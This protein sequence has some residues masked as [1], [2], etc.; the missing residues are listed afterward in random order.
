[1]LDE[2]AAG[3]ALRTGR[4]VLLALP[5][6]AGVVFRYDNTNPDARTARLVAG[7][8]VERAAGVQDKVPEADDLVRERGSRYIDF[9]IPGLLGMNLMGSGMWGSDFPSWMRGG[10]SCSNG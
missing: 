10:K 5:G 1:M 4:I 7:R 3:Q 2:T 9:L 6:H 8:A